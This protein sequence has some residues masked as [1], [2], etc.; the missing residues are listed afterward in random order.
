MRF[1][2]RTPH[3][4]ALPRG[5]LVGGGDARVHAGWPGLPIAI[6]SPEL[7]LVWVHFV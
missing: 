1:V 2:V 3:P 7:S 5:A 6:G 4:R